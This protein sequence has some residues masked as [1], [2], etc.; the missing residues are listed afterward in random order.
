MCFLP[1]YIILVRGGIKMIECLT[2]P[3]YV[4]ASVASCA[5]C[6]VNSPTC[7]PNVPTCNPN[8]P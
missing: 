6:P 7:N 5:P 1:K 4:S 8:K 3:D 2:N